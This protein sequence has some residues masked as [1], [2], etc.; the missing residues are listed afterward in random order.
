MEFRVKELREKKLF[1]QSDLS[2]LSGVSQA[3]ISLIESGKRKNP[4]IFAVAA[5][6]DALGVKLDDI[7]VK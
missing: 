5:L 6:A 7:I 3:D 4:S 1:S 2:K